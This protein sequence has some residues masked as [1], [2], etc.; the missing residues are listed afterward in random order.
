MGLL[1]HR[2]AGLYRYITSERTSFPPCLLI[3]V[4]PVALLL[5]VKNPQSLGGGRGMSQVRRPDGHAENTPY[6]TDVPMNRPREEDQGTVR[7]EGQKG[8]C[9]ME[10]V[11]ER[12]PHLQRAGISRQE[13]ELVINWDEHSWQRRKRLWSA[14]YQTT[15]NSP[16]KP[17]LPQGVVFWSGP[18][19]F[20]CIIVLFQNKAALWHKLS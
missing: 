12:I 5:S 4:P 7:S 8:W 10:L 6:R 14:S 1:H 16:S 9:T 2:V 3:S 13:Q 17:L 15:Q 11:S 19:S 18:T 20:K